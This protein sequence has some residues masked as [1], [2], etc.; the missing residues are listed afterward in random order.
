MLKFFSVDYIIS[1]AVVFTAVFL[2]GHEPDL[3][4]FTGSN[5]NGEKVL[6]K[7]RETGNGFRCSV[8]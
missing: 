3:Y 6:R 2:F 4:D 5:L 7:R 1:K 8:A